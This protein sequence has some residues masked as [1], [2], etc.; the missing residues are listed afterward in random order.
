M[1]CWFRSTGEVGRLLGLT[2]VTA[3]SCHG[4]QQ[5]AFCTFKSSTA[6]VESFPVSP[7]LLCT[8]VG[9]LHVF[10]ASRGTGRWLRLGEKTRHTHVDCLNTVSSRSPS[11]YAFCPSLC[12][13]QAWSLFLSPRCALQIPCDGFTF[14]GQARL[15]RTERT[16]DPSRAGPNVKLRC[17]SVNG[18]PLLNLAGRQWGTNRQASRQCQ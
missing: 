16:A 8:F 11:C 5:P 14:L 15:C 12:P 17:N 7:Q 9:V 1:S 2:G 6:R 4:R 3:E 18:V 10:S 13:H